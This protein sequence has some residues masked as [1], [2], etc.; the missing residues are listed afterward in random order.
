M[1]EEASKEGFFKVGMTKEEYPKIQIIT[2]KDLLDN[3]RLRLPSSYT[4]YQE[5][6]GIKDLST[7][8][9]NQKRLGHF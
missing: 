6:E 3:E 1:K 8:R 7:K 9:D 5:A 2:I 4:P